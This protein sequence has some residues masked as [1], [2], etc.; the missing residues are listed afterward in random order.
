MVK[1]I[2]QPQPQAPQ[3]VAKPL[4][5]K[6]PDEQDKIKPPASSNVDQK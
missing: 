4:V 2:D 5:T 3:P 6:L 1:E